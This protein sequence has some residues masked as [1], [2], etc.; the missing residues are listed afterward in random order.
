MQETHTELLENAPVKHALL[1]LGIPAM[2]GMLISTVYNLVD[3][4]FIGKLG[5]L[6]TAAVTVVYP[7]TMVAMGVGLLFGN[8]AGSNISRLLGKKDAEQVGAFSST[9]ILSGVAVMAVLAA[10]MLLFLKPLMYAL[11]ASRSSYGFARDYG[12]LYIIGLIFNVFNMIMNNLIAAEGVSSFGMFAML[13]GGCANLVLDPIFIFACGW[14][15]GGAAAATLLSRLVSSA[16][17]IGYL[18]RGKSCLRVSVRRFRPNGKLYATIFRIGLPVCLFQFLAGAAVT[19]TNNAAKPFGEAA[20]AA[21]GIVNRIMSIETNA[22]YGFLKGYS[23][24]VGYSYGAGDLARVREATR[25]AARWSTAAN[26]LFGV[27]CIVLAGPLIHLFNQ[28]S[29]QVLSIGSAALRVD[30]VSFMLLGVQI[31]IGNYF[32][33]TGKARQGGMLSVFRQGLFFIPFLLVLSRL[34]GIPGMI[35]AQLAADVC[36]TLLT[37]ALWKKERALL[38]AA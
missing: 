16:F 28:S 5:T 22:L 11:G 4:F 23:P 19:L 38:P 1:R 2:T 35:G 21:M 27:I 37:L 17:Y 36:A 14:G 24:L 6:Q 12:I 15:V 25:T 3:A 34:W 29:A 7:L 32:L 33:A 9:A 31:V 8:G 26:I 18:L 13:A 10:G 30:A 20:V